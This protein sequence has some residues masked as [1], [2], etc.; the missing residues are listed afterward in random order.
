V[1]F[2]RR[3]LCNFEVCVLLLMSFAL[4]RVV[5][6]SGLPLA[7]AVTAL[8]GFAL[9]LLAVSSG[10]QR[11]L[12]LA[13]AAALAWLALLAPP[14]WL[15]VCL[16]LLA[17]TWLVPS[18]SR[19]P[20]QPCRISLGVGVLCPALLYGALFAASADARSALRQAFRVDSSATELVGLALALVLIVA[21]TLAFLAEANAVPR[22]ERTRLWQGL[23][24]LPA[25]VLALRL[26]WIFSVASLRTDLLVWSEPPALVN[27][28]KLAAG[29][30][31]YGPMEWA[32]S[33]SYSPG[34]EL[35][36][37]AILRPLRLGLSLRAHR[38]LGIVWQLWSAWILSR[39]LW[40]WLRDQLEPHLKSMAGPTLFVGL[41][42]VTLSSF[43][44]PHVHP[45]HLLLLCFCVAIQLCLR[46][47]P[48][49]SRDWPLLILVP[50]AATAFKLT[51][52]GV[53]LGLV[54]AVALGRHWRA[55][56]ILV[57]AGVF[58]ALTVPLFDATLGEFSN[59]AIRLQ[60]SHR[61]EWWRIWQVP[62]AV[63]VLPFEVALGAASI[64]FWTRPTGESTRAAIRVLLLTIGFGSTSL[65]A[66]LKHGGRENSLLPWA[67]GG[68]VALL[69]LLSERSKEPAGA[70]Q[71]IM[72]ERTPSGLVIVAV[73]W[74]ALSGSWPQAP[75]VGVARGVLVALHD[76]Q[77]TWITGLLA[78]GQRPL[79]SS[80]AAG[81]DAGRRDVPR[82]CLSSVTELDLGHWRALHGFE[83]RISDGTY[84]GLFVPAVA[85]LDNELLLRLRP[86]LEREYQV[87]EPTSARGSWPTDRSGYVILE[88]RPSRLGITGG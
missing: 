3:T 29:E 48:F 58:A 5:L 4:P 20:R 75:V 82:D 40:P 19:A 72:G 49:R 10:V 53:G 85:L 57:L 62:G 86:R 21:L 34:L 59:Y 81:I 69:V 41:S 12:Q 70:T 84:A 13:S 63:P 56:G 78:Q 52:A 15:A 6:P 9:S 60:A 76:G 16:P 54:F 37:Y 1:T 22:P 27:L 26:V 36:Q 65:L 64:A 11:L 39:A 77:T 87:L 51:G 14:V 38:L 55:L 46:R 79:A 88:R 32:N 23:A 74:L 67:I 71:E 66:Y 44:A 7:C 31:F 8:G 61:I 28:L 80:P 33:Y 83:Q 50:V 35:T 45:D 25:V 73:A 24:A 17:A 47:E 42:S 30:R 2:R 68:S 18:L 43:L